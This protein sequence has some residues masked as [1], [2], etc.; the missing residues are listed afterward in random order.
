M[1]ITINSNHV[2]ADQIWLWRADHGAG[3]AWTTN[4]T[5][6]GLVVNGND[7]TIYGLF[8]E[9]HEQ[10]QTLWNGNGGRVYFYQ[11]EMP[12]DVPDQSVL[13]ERHDQ[14]LRVVQGRRHG[15]QPRGLGRGRVLPTSATRP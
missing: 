1:G 9:H 10:Y 14:R 11:S 12:Y 13:D 4:P 3:A 15:D 5:K 8:N 6:N 7:V 2:V